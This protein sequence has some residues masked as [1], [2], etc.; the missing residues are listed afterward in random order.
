MDSEGLVKW[1]MNP[2]SVESESSECCQPSCLYFLNF[3]GNVIF[4][5][6]TTAAIVMPCAWWHQG[7]NGQLQAGAY[8]ITEYKG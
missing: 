4:P 6:F 8:K 1:R 2:S 5:F 3:V 7:Y